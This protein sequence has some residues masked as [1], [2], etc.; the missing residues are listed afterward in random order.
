MTRNYTI[1]LQFSGLSE[2]AFIICTS[3]PPPNKKEKVHFGQPVYLTQ[4]VYIMS[5]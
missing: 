1:V 3:L 2:K 4:L 5:V